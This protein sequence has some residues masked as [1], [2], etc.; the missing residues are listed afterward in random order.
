MSSPIRRSDY[1]AS[2]HAAYPALRIE[3][4]RLNDE[5]QYNDILIVNGDLIFRFPRH[6]EG[7]EKLEKEIALLDRIRSALPLPIPELTYRR[8]VPPAV[9]HVFAGYRMLPGEPLWRETFAAITD[10]VIRRRL[11]M[12]LAT[13]LRA[14][15]GI[16]TDHVAAL[17]PA[18]DWRQLWADLDEEI[19]TALF[20]HLPAVAQEQ[21]AARFAAFLDDPDNFA[22]MPTVIHGDFGSGNLLWDARAGAMTAVIDFGSA[23]L[24]DPALDVA[25]LLTYGESFVRLGFAAYPAMETMLPRA[26]FYLSTFLLQEALYGI[27]HDDPDAVAR[28]LAPFLTDADEE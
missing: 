8:L 9:G 28:G 18:A 22:F 25:A 19:R 21:I 24:G 16:P 3:R 23:G 26:R 14:L 11:A 27:E 12:H 4:M 2:I 20:P 15:H 10:P 13:F 17:L 7:I 6:A 1:I 5:G